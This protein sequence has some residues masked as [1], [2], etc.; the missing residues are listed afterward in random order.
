[1]S[2]VANPTSVITSVS[3]NFMDGKLMTIILARVSIPVL[4][5]P[6]ETWLA[7]IRHTRSDTV[8]PCARPFDIK[9]IVIYFDL[10]PSGGDQ[11]I[12]LD[13]H[14]F[15]LSVPGQSIPIAQVVSFPLSW[16]VVHWKRFSNVLLAMVSHIYYGSMR[17]ERRGQNNG[18]MFI[19]TIWTTRIWSPWLCTGHNVNRDDLFVGHDLG[20]ANWLSPSNAWLCQHALAYPHQPLHAFPYSGTRLSFCLLILV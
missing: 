13:N 16:N 12:V 18:R 9:L 10:V 19:D 11:T 6:N 5:E 2:P 8:R 7:S 1:M 15:R 20:S 17:I 3:S 4:I 14:W